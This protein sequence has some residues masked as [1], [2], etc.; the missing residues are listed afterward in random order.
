MTESPSM[1]AIHKGHCGVNR[2]SKGADDVE[3][4]EWRT[5]SSPK[6]ESLTS[7]TASVPPQPRSSSEL[8]ED[9]HPVITEKHLIDVSPCT[10][11]FGPSVSSRSLHLAPPTRSRSRL[12]ERIR[13]GLFLSPRE[14]WFQRNTSVEDPQTKRSEYVMQMVFF[15]R[16]E[17]D[18]EESAAQHSYTAPHT[19]KSIG[20]LGMKGEHVEDLDPATT[21]SPRKALSQLQ[22][23][24]L[25]PA[26]KGYPVPGSES[27]VSTR[28]TGQNHSS[29]DKLEHA[30]STKSAME[31]DQSLRNES[32]EVLETVHAGSTS[33]FDAE[34]VPEASNKS[35]GTASTEFPSS[36]NKQALKKST[37]I[38]QASNI[39]SSSTPEATL[40]VASAAS[41]LQSTKDQAMGQKFRSYHS[42]SDRICSQHEK[43][44]NEFDECHDKRTIH[45]RVS[46]EVTPNVYM[47]LR[48]AMETL[49]AVECGRASSVTCVQCL[50]TLKCVPDAELVMCPDCR[51]TSP[52]ASDENDI[53]G[54]PV[55]RGVGLGLKLPTTFR[56]VPAKK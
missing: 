54:R 1:R 20:T 45:A 24:A 25:P 9:A 49:R 50:G 11:A 17:P 37:K 28:C 55:R 32:T 12:V 7:K 46:V 51:V 21:A 8:V 2:I 13:R 42:I 16:L 48:S 44:K 3:T 5:N 6:G 4:K 53:P 29:F 39:V 40:T 19:E 30:S 22:S 27:S 43:E 35:A 47:E 23:P 15:D 56:A 33:P 34:K 14:S 41:Q 18:L 38:A 10:Q 52:M 26:Q 31:Q 36:E